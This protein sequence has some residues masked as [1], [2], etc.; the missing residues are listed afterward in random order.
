MGKTRLLAVAVCAAVGVGVGASAAL[1]GEVK[2]PPGVPCGAPDQP[3]CAPGGN[4]NTTAGPI[5]AN[6]FCVFSGLNDFD[7]SDP[8]GQ[9]S[10]ITQTPADAPFPGVPGHGIPDTP[11][12]NGCRGG[13]N[14]ERGQA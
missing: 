5:H 6:S 12:A 2:G 13:S 11:F 10:K 8:L 14:L 9:T 4:T 7:G 1:A 3:E